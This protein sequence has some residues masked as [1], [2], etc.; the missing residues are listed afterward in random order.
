MNPTPMVARRPRVLAAVTQGMLLG[1]MRAGLNA[2]ELLAHSNLRL[3]DIQ[4]RDADVDLEQHAQIA[5]VIV[6]KLPGINIGLKTGMAATP[7]WFGVLGYV[8]RHAPTFQRLLIDFARFQRLVTDAVT[9]HI[10][11][12]PPC[13]VSHTLH[14]L[15]ADL[16]AAAEAYLAILVAVGR[17]LTGVQIIPMRV[18]FKHAPV[19]DPEEH[20]ALFGIPVE[21]HAEADELV[22]SKETLDLAVLGADEVLRQHLLHHA[23]AVLNALCTLPP[24][25]EA[26][27]QHF[28]KTL[29]TATPRRADV[30]K[31]LGVSERTL[32]RRLSEE[33]QTFESL[34]DQTR[35]ELALEYI[36]DPSLAV[37][38][39]AALL[40]YTEPSAFHRAFRRWTNESPSALRMRARIH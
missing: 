1:A 12:G 32:L 34:L 38:E 3:E 29:Y 33:G 15:V 11:L 37:F 5:R 24:T 28:V 40:G 17:Q 19:G 20:A 25:S 6:S 21:F 2:A 26:L 23:Q 13:R 7:I 16:P 14:R 8:L 22:F 27:R 39:I 36:K 30:A 10:D 4:D 31:A 35:R 18:A 9:W